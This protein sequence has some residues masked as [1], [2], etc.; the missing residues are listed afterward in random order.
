M[1]DLAN[2]EKHSK[3]FPQMSHKGGVL[4]AVREHG[5][6]LLHAR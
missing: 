4:G 3:A 1:C 2:L 5:K 6:E